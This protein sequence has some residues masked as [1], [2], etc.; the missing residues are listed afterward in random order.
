MIAGGFVRLSDQARYD[1]RGYAE[2][3]DIAI[4][5]NNQATAWVSAEWLR[6]EIAAH[7]KPSFLQMLLT[8]DRKDSPLQSG[9]EVNALRAYLLATH[10]Q[11]LT[12]ASTPMLESGV[13][14]GCS[15]PGS[16]ALL[17][18]T[19]AG[20]VERGTGEASRILRGW[21][22]DWR[23]AGRPSFKQLRA[24]CEKNETNWKVQVTLSS[25]SPSE[26]EG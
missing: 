16:L 12:T 7:H 18:L 15:Q 10:P 2:E 26:I 19:N 11:S 24:F 23:I 21:I 17:S 3:A 4:L 14:I 6:D 1:W 22:S 9:E 5:E 8:A 13:A 20:Y 25:S